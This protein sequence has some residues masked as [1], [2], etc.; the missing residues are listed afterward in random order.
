MASE[1]HVWL[2][3]IL[4]ELP[5]EWEEAECGRCGP[6]TSEALGQR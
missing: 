1:D 4:F 6:K 3:A 5:Q 2:N